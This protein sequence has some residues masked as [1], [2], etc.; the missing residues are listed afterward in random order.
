MDENAKFALDKNIQLVV[1]G[2]SHSECAFD[3][4]KIK[5]FK[6]LSN[7]GQSYFYLLPKLR[8]VIDHNPQIKTVMIEFSN[9]QIEERMD[10]WIW[11]YDKLANFYPIYAPFLKKKEHQLLIEKNPSSV[12]SVIP[13]VAKKNLGRT[14]AFNWD[15]SDDIGKFKPLERSIIDSLLENRSKGFKEPSFSNPEISEIHLAYLDAMVTYCR[16][17]NVNVILVRSPQH[18]FY[19]YRANEDLFQKIRK[20]RYGTLQFLDFNDF[21]LKDDQFADFA[22]VNKAGA[23]LFSDW[24]DKEV[25]KKLLL[26]NQ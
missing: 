2:H 24:F 16:A 18:R 3:D 23:A 6:N 9:G 10:D 26:G 19:N 4:T 14:L 17:K 11:G 8:K 5:N 22:H 20:E 25:A 12:F 13:I 1:F 7:A 15:Y 21:P